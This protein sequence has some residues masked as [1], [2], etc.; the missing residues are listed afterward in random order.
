MYL[1]VYVMKKINGQQQKEHYKAINQDT[2][3]IIELLPEYNDMS[4]GKD[5]AIG[6][7]FL[8]RYLAD[9]Y[10]AGQVIVR[11]KPSNAPRYYDKQFKKLDPHGYADLKSQ[12]ELEIRG[13]WLEQTH[14]RLRVKE[15][16]TQAK[17]KFLKRKI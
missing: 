5:N 13:N 12:R 6:K 4:R 14:E 10:P 17:L 11:G 8:N 2:G 9:V 3:E 7:Q 15:E 16:V 1:S